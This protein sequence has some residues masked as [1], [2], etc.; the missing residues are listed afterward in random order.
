VNVK[1]YEEIDAEYQQRI[2]TRI[3]THRGSEDYKKWQKDSRK[4]RG[5]L[6]MS[7]GDEIYQDFESM[8]SILPNS[9]PCFISS[10]LALEEWIVITTTLKNLTAAYD[11]FQTTIKYHDMR[12][13][14]VHFDTLVD[15]LIA[16]EY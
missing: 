13:K 11:T 4:A 1:E 8:R 5:I 9:G 16:E 10:A 2:S 6:G 3:S 14:K 7:I 12:T 15:E